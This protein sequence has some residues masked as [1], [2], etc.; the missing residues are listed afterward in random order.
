MGNRILADGL[1]TFGIAPDGERVSLNVRDHDGTEAAL[2]L[3]TLCL[4]QMLMTLPRIIQTA[5]RKARNDPSLRLVH[6]LETY[7][8]ELGTPDA[9]GERRLILTLRTSGGFAVS[10]ALTNDMVS[11]LAQSLVDQAPASTTPRMPA[12]LN[13]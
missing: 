5:L 10:F 2:E 12:R 9:A 3:P 1:T 6:A 7:T 13:S 11:H 4:N 8:L